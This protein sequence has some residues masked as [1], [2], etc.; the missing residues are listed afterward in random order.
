MMTI[1]VTCASIA[2]SSSG[3]TITIAMTAITGTAIVGIGMIE[4]IA[5]TTGI[6]NITTATTDRSRVWSL[7][8]R[9]LRLTLVKL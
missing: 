8:G 1:I 7:I 4:T 3:T 9:L 6:T 2:W 5:I